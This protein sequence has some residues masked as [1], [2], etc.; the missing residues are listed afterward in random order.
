MRFT[1]F[2]ARAETCAR[3]CAIALGFSIPVSVAL[4]N[5]LLALILASWIAS[6]GY[7]EKLDLMLHNRVAVAA[8]ALFCLFAAGLIHSSANPGDGLGTLGKYLD[9]A[10]VPVFVSVFRD[11]RMRHYAWLAFAFALA[12]TLILSYLT[13]AGLIT[14]NLSVIGGHANP[15]VFKQYLTQSVM[16]AFGAFLFAQLARTAQSAQHRYGWSALATLA[17][18]NVAVMN[19]GRTGQLILIALALYFVHSVWRWRGTLGA[20]VAIII[21]M[22]ALAIG[23]TGISNRFAQAYDEWKN[24]QPAQ[25]AQTSIGF[26]LEFYRNSLEIVREHPLVGTGTGSFRKVYADHVAGTAR[27]A[28]ANPHNEYLSITVQLGVVG[29][30]MM[31]YV[32]YT[33]WRLAAALP[34]AHERQLAHALVITFVIGCLFNS[35]LMDHTEG[36]LFAWAS[37]LLFAGL[38]SPPAT[39]VAPAR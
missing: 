32:F 25:A 11:E 10:F 13:W 8:F 15:V 24:W 36:L 18:V 22:S 1:T 21:V 20:A 9:L 39:S 14:N 5:I 28:T 6:G 19:Q 2:T 34:T 31:L 17:V 35:L 33:E 12:L 37:G 38:K 16:M 26:R 29:L 3:A 23:N 30:L 27:A 4:D 7:R